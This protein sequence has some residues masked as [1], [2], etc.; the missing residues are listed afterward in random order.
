MLNGRCKVWKDEGG[1]YHAEL[2]LDA[3]KG[4]IK[5]KRTAALT[6]SVSGWDPRAPET[7]P[8]TLIKK[9]VEYIAGF[10]P[11][12]EVVGKKAHDI[13][14]KLIAMRADDAT[15]MKAMKHI[16]TIKAAAARGDD[17]AF[18]ID[19]ALRRIAKG[20]KR[21]QVGSAYYR[22]VL[23][24]EPETLDTFDAGPSAIRT[25][26]GW[27]PFKKLA[28][29]AKKNPIKAV[30]SAVLPP[31]AAYNLI[32][33][34]KKKKPAAV[35]QVAT[36]RRWSQGLPA[37]RTAPP[38]SEYESQ[39]AQAALENLRAADAFEAEGVV[40]P[41]TYSRETP[42]EA[43]QY[44]DAYVPSEEEY[45]DSTEGDAVGSIFSKLKKAASSAL[46]KID[47]T[48]PGSFTAPLLANLPMVGPGIK[49]GLD[50]LDQAKKLNPS[51]IEKIKTVKSLAEAGVPKAIAAKDNLL[52]AQELSRAAE[53]LAAEGA[54]TGKTSKV[55]KNWFPLIDLYRQG[56]TFSR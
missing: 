21:T 46:S 29:W 45:Y 36:I 4:V 55:G 52:T 7:G 28:K 41:Q 49:A 26:I 33:A 14:Q 43:P 13:A 34:A 23:A 47:P 11:V 12:E 2:A 22:G 1:N 53:K 30:A 16:N 50:L 32:R 37:T 48:R 5:M 9:K 15:A 39:K 38:P 42:Y 25:E 54:S 18:D 10:F 8:G 56:M 19:Y 20:A 31:V 35:Q 17:E 27:K 44:D 3:P 51:A 40:P 24:G 6:D